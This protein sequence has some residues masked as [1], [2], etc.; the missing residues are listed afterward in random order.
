MKQFISLFSIIALGACFLPLHSQSAEQ[1][2]ELVVH[3]DCGS[4]PSALMVDEGQIWVVFAQNDQVYFTITNDFGTSYKQPVAVN[5][6]PEAIYTNGENRP[7]VAMGHAGELYVSWTHKTEGRYT[8]DIRFSRSLDSG[9]T[10]SAPV[11]MNNDGLLISHRF[12]SLQVAESGHVYITWLDKRDQVAIR[13][14]GG[15]YEGAALYFAVSEDS[16]GSFL[17]PQSLI[18]YPVADNSC[19]CCRI[20]IDTYGD[21]DVA[22]VWRHIFGETTRDHAYAIL[23]SDGTSEYG[24]ATVDN[25]QINACPHHGPDMTKASS[26]ESEYH[27]VWFSNGDDHTG[28]YYGLQ[29]LETGLG[30]QRYSV[31]SSAGASHPQIVN[32]GEGLYIA[33]KFFDGEKTHIQLIRSSDMGVTWQPEGSI[34]NTDGNSDH[35]SL[36]EYGSVVYLAWH[37]EQ[38]GY[39]FEKLN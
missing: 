5:N 12:D 17:N 37:S 7:K 24:R 10:F 11:T 38:E 21:N 28:I 2:C 1:N 18:N 20:A 31:D 6:V 32:N 25:W 39:R 36:I 13:E 3:V 26:K 35:P 15:E 14:D 16:G 22:V 33:W 34:L 29:D 4:T 19:E 9:K 30:T 23:K 27:M 8:G